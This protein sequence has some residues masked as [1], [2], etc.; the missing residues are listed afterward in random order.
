[1]F[2]KSL[3]KLKCFLFQNLGYGWLLSCIFN[4]DFNEIYFLIIR[5]CGFDKSVICYNI[6][7]TD[8]KKNENVVLLIK[9]SRNFRLRYLSVDNNLISIVKSIIMQYS[10]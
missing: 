7:W 10:K 2:L 9:C 4:I 8:I 6:P 3:I 1:M 5:L